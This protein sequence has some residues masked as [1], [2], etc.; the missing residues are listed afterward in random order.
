M[1]FGILGHLS[2]DSSGEEK[3]GKRQKLRKSPSDSEMLVWSPAP[4]ALSVAPAL[5]S[6]S[7]IVEEGLLTWNLAW[8]HMC[9]WKWK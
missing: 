8:Y 9:K 4:E 6:S 7:H 1:H 5:E 3:W 2:P